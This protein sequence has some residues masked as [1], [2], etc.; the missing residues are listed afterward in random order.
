MS[1]NLLASPHSQDKRAIVVF[2][3]RYGNMA[4]IARSFE[5]GLRTGGIATSLVEVS[6]VTLESLKDYDLLAVGGPTEIMTA[7][8]PIKEFLSKLEHREELRGKFGFAFDIKLGIPMTGSAAKFIQNKLKDSGL[9]IVTEKASA[10]VIPLKKKEI[11]R[12]EWVHEEYFPFKGDEEKRFEEIGRQVG[13]ALLR[14][15]VMKSEIPVLSTGKEG[16]PV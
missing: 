8:K 2:Y 16:E 13:A 10:L 3:S 11:D 1:A 7:P 5:T 14:A 12:K 4:K 6:E 15:A 9:D